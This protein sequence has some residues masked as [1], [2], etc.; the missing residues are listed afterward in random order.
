MDGTWRKRGWRNEWG[1]EE[2]ECDG[3]MC[4]GERERLRA[5]PGRL[6]DTR[7][8][9]LHVPHSPPA[10]AARTRRRCP[11]AATRRPSAAK[12]GT[13]NGLV[14]RQDIQYFPITVDLHTQTQ[15]TEHNTVTN[16]DPHPKWNPSLSPEPVTQNGQWISETHL[17]ILCFFFYTVADYSPAVYQYQSVSYQYMPYRDGSLGLDSGDISHALQTCYLTELIHMPVYDLQSPPHTEYR[18]RA[19]HRLQHSVLTRH[20]AVRYMHGHGRNQTTWVNILHSSNQT[21][22][23]P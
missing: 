18:T 14:C 19:H 21:R 9:G 22:Q 20:T 12:T 10:A 16:T 23:E 13:E 11:C 4:E 8:P 15:H 7:A 6:D 3:G 5:S 2:E 1:W 17:D